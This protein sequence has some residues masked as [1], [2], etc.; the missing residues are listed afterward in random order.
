MKTIQTIVDEMKK[1]LSEVH[2]QQYYKLVE[3]FQQDRRFFFTGEG[4][5]GF[6][7]KAVAM[8][9]MHAEKEVYVVG[10]TITPAIRTGD[11]LIVLS[12]SGTTSSS[13]HS[14]TQA[15]NS[16]ATVFLVTADEDALGTAPFQQGL[17]LP[18]ATKSKKHVHRKTI[19]PLGN[20]FDQ[21]AHLL[22][23]AAIIDAIE[24]TSYDSLKDNHANLE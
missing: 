7:M 19:Q 23:D 13:V 20:Q 18:A 21:A 12:G 24:G 3:L 16:G 10:E 9:M 1:V 4:R 11:A 15:T 17:V 8:R 22:L 5:S 2:P 14:A 6:I